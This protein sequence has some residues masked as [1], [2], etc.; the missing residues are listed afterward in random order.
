MTGTFKM[1]GNRKVYA[2]QN[3]VHGFRKG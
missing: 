3:T 2:T 1:N